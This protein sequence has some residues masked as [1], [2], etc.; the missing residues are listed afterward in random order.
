M[1]LDFPNCIRVPS[2][3]KKQTWT[4][5]KSKR[6]AD[7]F[8]DEVS[9]CARATEAAQGWRGHVVAPALVLAASES[10]VFAP[11]AGVLRASAASSTTSSQT[12]LDQCWERCIFS[13]AG[14]PGVGRGG[15]RG[16]L[17]IIF[18]PIALPKAKLTDIFACTFA[19]TGRHRSADGVIYINNW[20]C[21]RRRFR[22]IFYQ[23]AQ[24]ESILNQRGI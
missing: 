9:I 8:S 23:T 6:R 7:K 11:S 4:T 17:H 3:K 20:I 1:R 12:A 2:Q 10:G 24:F 14:A 16:K 5:K 19:D 13:L 21:Y 18:S 15:R 22:N